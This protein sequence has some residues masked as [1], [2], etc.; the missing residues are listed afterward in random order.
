[1]WTCPPAQAEYRGELRRDIDWQFNVDN[2][3][4]AGK[5]AVTVHYLIGRSGEAEISRD[6]IEIGLVSAGA[7]TQLIFS[8]PAR[9]VR[10]ILIEV[11]QPMNTTIDVEVIQGGPFPGSFPARLEGQPGSLVFDVVD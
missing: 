8:K 7:R 4:S 11:Q 2:S 10:R 1:M 9:G 3:S 6:D 5:T